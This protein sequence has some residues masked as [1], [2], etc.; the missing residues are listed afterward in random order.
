MDQCE[1]LFDVWLQLLS[2]L[3]VVSHFPTI[4]YIIWT[5]AS[6]YIS[7]WNEHREVEG[8]ESSASQRLLQCPQGEYYYN[9][10]TLLSFTVLLVDQVDTH[11]HAASCMNQKHLLR[12]IKK[13]IKQCPDDVVVASQGEELTLAK[14]GINLC[15]QYNNLWTCTCA[16]FQKLNLRAYDLTVDSLD[17]HAVSNLYTHVNN[18]FISDIG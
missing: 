1:C 6:S 8:T 4:D 12:F 9:A 3:F 14:V 17:V 18:F 7:C 13:K 11:I 5:L 10:T 16:G 2:L 15:Q